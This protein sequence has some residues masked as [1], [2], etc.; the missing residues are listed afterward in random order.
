MKK[1]IEKLRKWLI[2]KPAGHAEP[3]YLPAARYITLN[4]Q[5]IQQE[6]I[7]RPGDAIAIEE[8]DL[9]RARDK[10]YRGL[11]EGLVLSG[12]IRLQRTDTSDG[13]IRLR[14]SLVILPEIE[15]VRMN[16]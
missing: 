10:L 4:V 2:K 16:G 8:I 11:F 6:T 5:T 9:V 1:L 14:A 13:A 3:I 15:R 7:V 12:N